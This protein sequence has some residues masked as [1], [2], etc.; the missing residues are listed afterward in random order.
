MLA[1]KDE[2]IL[3]K[4]TNKDI[5]EN[6]YYLKLEIISNFLSIESF[7]HLICSIFRTRQI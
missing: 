1:L 3:E 5:F 6:N 2:G 7:A 4:T